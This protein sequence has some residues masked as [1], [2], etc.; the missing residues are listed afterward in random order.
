M[1]PFVSKRLNPRIEVCVPEGE[2][3]NGLGML[4]QQYLEQNFSDFDHK[5][6]QGLRIRGRVAVEV[7]KGIATTLHFQGKQIQIENGV[8]GHP[9][10]YLSSS[11]LLLSKVLSGKANPYFE[12][13]RGKIKLRAV[14][15]RPYQSI[16]AL[17]FLKIPPE[18]LFEPASSRLKQNIAW[19]VGVILGVA[20]LSVLIYQLIRLFEG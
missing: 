14:P 7:E 18:L 19:I 9:D 3:L 13:L 17:R 5:V 16:K 20:V 8:S 10:L 12:L 6:E 11:Y 4:L 1:D 15:R 2:P